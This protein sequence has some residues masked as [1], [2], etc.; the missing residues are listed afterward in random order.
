MLLKTD[1]KNASDF[2][3]VYTV[4]NEEISVPLLRRQVVELLIEEKKQSASLNIDF[5]VFVPIYK[6]FV[7]N[8][9]YKTIK[10]LLI[11]NN[12]NVFRIPSFSPFPLPQFLFRRIMGVGV[13]P[14]MV[15]HWFSLPFI[16]LNTFPIYL[17][18][19]LFRGVRIF[20][21]RSYASSLAAL[22]AKFILPGFKF[23]FDPR[24][25]FPEENVTSENWCETSLDF[26][27]W[28]FLER[29]FLKQADA[30]ICISKTYVTHFEKSCAAIKQ[31]VIPNN[32]DVEKFR[33]DPDFRRKFRSENGLEDSIVF[34]YLGGMSYNGWHRPDLYA[35]AIAEFRKIGKKSKFLFLVPDNAGPIL[36]NHFAL[37]GISEDEYIVH[38]PN[39]EDVPKFLSAS[40]YGVFFLDRRKISLGTKI[41]EY[42]AVGLPFIINS[43]VLGGL[44]LLEEADC[45]IVVD[46]GLGDRDRVSTVIEAAEQIVRGEFSQHMIRQFAASKFSNQ[47]V[48]GCYLK[49]YEELTG[50]NA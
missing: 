19:Y 37:S 12:I 23:V 15:Q 41:T 49:V 10:N 32:V 3:V 2:R 20:H 6:Y 1:K 47:V 11:N 33:F 16:A 43:N 39:F 46:I 40:D 24:S 38:H 35:G 13:R 34:G 25:D 8:K 27:V 14:N 17:L 7:S 21:C 18:F 45:G 4:Y 29:A 9:N 5:L 42:T 50:K 44:S 26:R 28:K 48:S 22:M 30:V 31:H 36:K